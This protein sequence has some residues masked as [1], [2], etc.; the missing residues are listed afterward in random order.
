MKFTTIACLL[1]VASAAHPP[2]ASHAKVKASSSEDKA[3]GDSHLS[4]LITSALA[5][6]PPGVITEVTPK[7]DGLADF[8]GKTWS[9]KGQTKNYRFDWKY[10]CAFTKWTPTNQWLHDQQL[11]GAVAYDPATM[12]LERFGFIGSEKK[13]YWGMVGVEWVTPLKVEQ[14]PPK[15]A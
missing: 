15:T 2:A 6:A 13:C 9:T 7:P 4:Q 12:T 5:G 14:I 10:A 8:E 11:A 1:G 3:D